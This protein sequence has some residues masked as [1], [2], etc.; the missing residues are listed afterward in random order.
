[1]LWSALKTFG[2]PD[3]LVLATSTKKGKDQHKALLEA[4]AVLFENNVALNF[5]KLFGERASRYSMTNVPTY[6]FQRQHHYP[7]TLPSRNAGTAIQ[8]A[9][10]EASVDRFPVDQPLCDLLNDHRIHGVPVLPAA[11]LADF[12]SRQSPSRSIEIIRF[13][14]GLFLE[15]PSTIVPAKFEASGQFTIHHGESRQEIDKIS[16]GTFGRSSDVPKLAQYSASGDPIRI[17]NHE[18]VYEPFTRIHFGPSFRNI[19]ELRMWDDHADAVVVAEPGARPEHDQMRALEPCLHMFGAVNQF[20][21]ALPQQ[22]GMQGAFLPVSLEG[23]SVYVD[24]FPPSFICRYCLP[25]DVD[26]DSHILSVSFEIISPAGELMASCR[27]YSV[28]WV[29]IEG[30]S[31]REKGQVSKE[32]AEKIVVAS[33]RQV[34]ELKSNEELGTRYT[35]IV[36]E[37]HADYSQILRDL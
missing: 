27:K 5:S 23:Y 9:P 1:M 24:K 15:D 2:L 26:K 8:A 12:V 36:C 4:V 25:V 20:F 10:R 34:L 16:S 29:S 32:D 37:L 18:Q 3:K 14:K 17:L 6:P 13:H 35:H 28:S 21:E 11:G 30:S 19:Q 22:A 33:L 31:V 7:A